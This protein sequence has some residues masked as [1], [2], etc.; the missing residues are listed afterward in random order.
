NQPADP[1][2]PGK[3]SQKSNPPAHAGTNQDLGPFR[4][5]VDH[6]QRIL[7]PAPDGPVA[8]VAGGGAMAEIVE[9]QE[10]LVATAA[11]G[12]QRRRLDAPH[13]GAESR[14]EHNTW[15][16]T[17]RFLTICSCRTVVAC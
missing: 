5:A 3:A 7:A 14:Q 8:E 9:A 4:Q 11:M 17:A 2:R 13:I 1:V 12:R 6:G 15:R 10:R 16:V